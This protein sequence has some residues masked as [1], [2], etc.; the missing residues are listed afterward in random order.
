MR[1]KSIV[2]PSSSLSSPSSSLPS[3][4]LSEVDR[5]VANERKRRATGNI[6]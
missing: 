2:T 4:P 5:M 6:N 3:K 1:R